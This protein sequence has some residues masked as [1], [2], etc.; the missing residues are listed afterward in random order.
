MASLFTKIIR[1]ELPSYK[2]LEN[3]LCYA[4]LA[5]DQI[6]P[7]HTLVVPK[8]EAET[9]LTLPEPSYTAV[10]QMAQKLGRA[11][12]QVTQCKRVGMALQGFEVAHCHVHLI[13]LMDPADFDFKKARRLETDEMKAI[14][15]RLQT[16]LGVK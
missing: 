5:L 11:I 2:I 14:Q 6:R 7:G 9:F 15:A 3:E 13:P 16:E 12:S 4:F 1:G 10:F 8:L